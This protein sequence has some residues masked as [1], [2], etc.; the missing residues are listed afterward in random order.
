MPPPAPAR[1][2][3]A[4]Q[5]GGLEGR[6]GG[7]RAVFRGELSLGRLQAEDMPRSRRSRTAHRQ[8]CREHPLH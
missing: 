4:D 5:G 1:E 6:D 8:L 7:R 3:P 2:R